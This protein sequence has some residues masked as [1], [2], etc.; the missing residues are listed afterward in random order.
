MTVKFYLNGKSVAVDAP[1]AITLL[2]L[3]REHLGLT[4]AKAGCERGECGACTVL[5]DGRPVPS[6][7]VLAGQVEGKN[8][9]TIEGL[10]EGDQLHPL[11]QAFIDESA[12]QCGYCIPGMI[13]SARA[14]LDETSDPTDEQ[15]KK[16]LSGNLCRCTG[17]SKIILAV[18]KAAEKIR[19]RQG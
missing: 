17:Y 8:V 14:L 15:I 13:M 5:I 6:C 16:A 3:L 12:V 1:P 10:A 4:G 19:D 18:K 9:E 2:Q 11:Q 7:L